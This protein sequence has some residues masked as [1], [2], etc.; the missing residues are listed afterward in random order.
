MAELRIPLPEGGAFVATWPDNVSRASAD[1]VAEIIG[2]RIA[3]W[4]P[5]VNKLI[6]QDAGIAAA[7]QMQEQGGGN[8]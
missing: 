4:K 6:G 7:F 8:G 3:S 2:A 1:M 5:I